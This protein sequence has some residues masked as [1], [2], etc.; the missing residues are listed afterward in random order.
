MVIEGWRRASPRSLSC[1]D[2]EIGK[3]NGLTCQTMPLIQFRAIE[4]MA[5]LT[6]FYRHRAAFALSDPAAARNR[7]AG[8][9]RRRENAGERCLRRPRQRAASAGEM[10]P[11]R[12][13]AIERGR[14]GRAKAFPEDLECRHAPRL[15]ARTHLFHHRIR[16]AHVDARA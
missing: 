8:A 3:W 14:R 6:G 15:Q 16:R 12:H 4:E 13:E 9:F 5:D 11:A 1:V 7:K 2:D 10:N